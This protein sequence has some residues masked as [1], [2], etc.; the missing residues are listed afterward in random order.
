MDKRHRLHRSFR[1]ERLAIIALIGFQLTN[2]LAF[3][4]P[5]GTTAPALD[6][7]FRT[8]HDYPDPTETIKSLNTQIQGKQPGANLEMDLTY[9][10]LSYLYESFGNHDAALNLLTP[11]T[12]L[13]ANEDMKN[14]AY[15]VQGLVWAANHREKKETRAELDSLVLSI[16]YAQTVK[17]IAWKQA[18]LWE[19]REYQFNFLVANIHKVLTLDHEREK[20][21]PLNRDDIYILLG[22]YYP[23]R[24][25]Q[26]NNNEALQ[27]KKTALAEEDA[28]NAAKTSKQNPTAEALKDAQS[29]LD[30]S[31]WVQTLLESMSDIS[32]VLSDLDRIKFN[33]LKLQKAYS[34]KRKAE[35]LLFN[36]EVNQS[37][38]LRKRVIG[39]FKKEKQYLAREQTITRLI[40]N[41]LELK[42]GI[43]LLSS[44]PYIDTQITRHEKIASTLNPRAAGRFLSSKINDFLLRRQLYYDLLR[45]PSAL[46]TDNIQ[47]LSR[48][49]VLSA[50]S[51][52][53]R[54]IR[55]EI[56]LFGDIDSSSKASNISARL[57]EFAHELETAK[58]QLSKTLEDGLPRENFQSN[59]LTDY[60]KMLKTAKPGTTIRMEAYEPSKNKKATFEEGSYLQLQTT[61]QKLE[62]KLYET[63][64]AT[65]NKKSNGKIIIDDWMQ[66]VEGMDPDEAIVCYLDYGHNR[67]L[68]AA[69]IRS[70]GE[71][72]LTDLPFGNL[73]E[74]RAWIKEAQK[75]LSAN[76]EKAN[77]YIQK[78]S[79]SLWQPLESTLPHKV[80]II[81]TL[82]LLGFP[83][84][85]LNSGNGK[86]VIENHNIQYAIGLSEGVG[87]SRGVSDSS[88][89]VV[90]GAHTFDR[91][92]MDSLPSSLAEINTIREF[93]QT[94][95][96][97]LYPD[98]PFPDGYQD[99]LKH[100]TE[101]KVLHVSTH[102]I[103]DK[104]NSLFDS[105]VFPAKNM[106][107]FE[108][109]F[110]PLKA[111]LAVFSACNILKKRADRFHPLSGMAVGALS[112]IA[113]QLITSLWSV[114]SEGSRLFMEIFYRKLFTLNDPSTAL[115]E[116]KK[117]FINTRQLDNWLKKH[118]VSLPA[119]LTVKD[120][121][122]S[123][124]WSSY[125]LVV[126]P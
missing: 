73:L 45:D 67:P 76:S 104:E 77:S 49:F 91:L 100:R 59:S 89:A 124:Y 99:W 97:K 113:P 56:K 18:L 55:H 65:K 96:L 125:V 111:D 108:M 61:K 117:L 71:V 116:T 84:E 40:S 101:A 48:Q 1:I 63:A 12:L 15:A 57:E 32:V 51:L 5:A 69:V 21:I 13:S 3:S 33:S 94:K 112:S 38:H 44:T 53:L 126:R 68:I 92:G 80:T 75:G 90:V 88:K 62:E 29:V 28:K 50:D 30:M 87:R 58:A 14:V 37:L 35:L 17:N 42:K 22:I 115:A 6:T 24:L 105:L 95:G 20:G 107:A 120:L 26:I 9:L 66:I 43:Y 79:E 25:Y 106:F 34:D 8:Y 123:Y 110:S 31:P 103:M 109:A 19:V 98:N 16:H 119:R 121:K 74:L 64:L 39:I 36:G 4:S 82:S 2:F 102:A 27:N 122:S 83:F 78:L 85:T 72:T 70:T 60:Y 86:K 47:K 46:A 10:Q 81:P 118:K 52:R 11:L 114:S 41:I 54:S 23:H 7:A 93:L